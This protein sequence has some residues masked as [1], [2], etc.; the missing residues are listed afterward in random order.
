[1]NFGDIPQSSLYI[2]KNRFMKFLKIQNMEGKMNYKI[3][4]GSISFGA[5]TILEEIN[6]EIKEKEKIAIVG[7]NGAGKTTLLKAL[8]DNS[9]LEPGI[10]EEKFN[11]IK[12]GSFNIGYLKQID[13]ENTSCTMLEEI[14]KV[15][16]PIIQL[17]EKIDKL[18]KKLT[19]TSEIQLIKEYTDSLEKLKFMG[20][21]EYKKEYETAIK[22]FGFTEEDKSKKIYEFSG[23]QRT[24]IA[25]LKLLLSKPELL[26]LDEPTNHLDIVAIEWL[27][28]Y[29][30]NY[31]GAIVIVSH[32]RMF[33]DRIV[34]KVYEIEYA[35]ITE[36]KGNYTKFE[37][38]KKINYE[39]QLKDYEYQQAEIKRLQSIADRF[40]Y[41]P[42]KAKM[43]LSKLKKIEQMNIIEEPNK[44][45]LKTFNSNF[46]IEYKS[47]QNVLRV[48]DLEIGY[49]N[50][51]ICKVSFELY[52]GQK[53][54]IIGENGIGKSTLLKTLN[55]NIQKL[56]GEM[57]YGH[58]VNIGYF[59]QLMEFDNPELTVFDELYNKFPELTTTQ[60]R[61]LLGTFLFSGEDVFKKIS[62]LSGG[63]KVRLQLC[64][65]LKKGPNL[66]LLDEP[67]NHTDI[68]GKETLERILKE[69]KGTVMFIS[70]DRYFVNKIAD[71]ILEFEKGKV[72]FYKGNYDE[73]LLHKT[74]EESAENEN[75]INLIQNQSNINKSKEDN[76]YFIN[77]ELNKIKNKMK[78]IEEEI[79][80][81]ESET[82]KIKT[83]MLSPEINTDYL[84]LKE[85]QDKIENLDN[86]IYIKMEEWEELNSKLNT[87]TKG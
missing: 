70:H 37:E 47:G 68:L 78:K 71:S 52:R 11:I 62:L 69:Y 48:K 61:T 57:E 14:L 80:A 53:L 5:E 18:A 55:G 2:I 76:S 85:L 34:N 7:R 59:D 77:K 83:E 64:E 28:N 4:N 49:N 43:A 10:G 15:Y 44:Y 58:H 65:I 73:Y 30:K 19:N 36:Y 86:T 41:K 54:A 26:L 51:P 12:Q 32:D 27:E 50:K 9:M 21:Y 17:E 79:D 1:M 82:D 22:K 13:F 39:K 60:I 20:G 16:K 24:K 38:Q 8:I 31:S 3:V 84:K 35:A 74:K 67:T 42:T 46:N 40:R 72:T 25:F 56:G 45:D 66:L 87:I 6:F 23:G 63:E 29:L 75:K 81:L 33:L